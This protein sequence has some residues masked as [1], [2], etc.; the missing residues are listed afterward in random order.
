MNITD[1]IAYD[2][3]DAI[4]KDRKVKELFIEY[5]RLEFSGGGNPRMLE[6]ELL[7]ALKEH[8]KRASE[9]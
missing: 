4:L 5:V 9:V 1:R 6:N 2:A 7:P 8:M 3:M